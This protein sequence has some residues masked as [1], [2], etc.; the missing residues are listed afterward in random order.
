MIDERRIRPLNGFIVLR[1]PKEPEGV[2]VGG[3][4]VPGQVAGQRVWRIATVVSLDKRGVPNKTGGGFHPHVLKIGDQVVLDKIFGDRII[5]GK[6]TSHGLRVVSEDQI[7]GVISSSDGS[8]VPED[9]I[10]DP[11]LI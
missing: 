2:Q 11:N 9:L 4:M 1:F 7:T 8:R 3:L 6:M 5:D 10:L